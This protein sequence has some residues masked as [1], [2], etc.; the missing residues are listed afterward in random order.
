MSASTSPPL[1]LSPP[2]SMSASLSP[3][4]SFLSF[5]LSSPWVGRPAGGEEEVR[6]SAARWRT[7]TTMVASAR[8]SSPAAHWPAREELTKGQHNDE[9]RRE[10]TGGEARPDAAR[11]APPRRHRPVPPHRR[12]RPALPH[13]P[14]SSP[15]ERGG[16]R[17]RGGEMRGSRG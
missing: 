15:V 2:R 11:A 4:L 9:R 16:E 12:R 17:K 8:S 10:M 3:P 6:R 14:Y 1:F 7:M 13:P 5:S